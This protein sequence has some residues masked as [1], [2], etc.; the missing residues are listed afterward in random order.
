MKYI[1]SPWPPLLALTLTNLIC[2]LIPLPVIL[3]LLLNSCLIIHLGVILSCTL[4]KASY[5]QIQ[6]SEQKMLSVIDQPSGFSYAWQI[7]QYPVMGCLFLLTLY[8][9][10]K[11]M[12]AIT[13]ST[14]L[15]LGFVVAVVGYGGRLL[16]QIALDVGGSSGLQGMM[17]DRVWSL[18]LTVSKYLFCPLISLLTA[19]VYVTGHHWLV[20]NLFAVLLGVLAIKSGGIRSFRLVVPILWSLF[21]YDMYWV[22]NS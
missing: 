5:Q 3:Q 21:L 12:E 16:H 18:L 1:G 13:M 8:Y 22:Y 6:Q 17:G 14:V 20:N 4:S 9:L 2:L 7:L 11:T 10:S 19:L 15:D